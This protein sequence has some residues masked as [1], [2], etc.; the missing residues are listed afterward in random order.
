MDR[1]EAIKIINPETRCD[2]LRNY[3]YSERMYAVNE[4]CKIAV[5]YLSKDGGL[6][7]QKHGLWETHLLPLAWKCSVCG[8][9]NSFRSGKSTEYLNYCPCCG[10]KM[11]NIKSI[12]TIEPP[13]NDPLTLEELREMDGEPVWIVPTQE[14]VKPEYAL[15]SVENEWF[16][17]SNTDYWE[18]DVYG[19]AIIAYRRKPE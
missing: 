4:A 5:S 8:F 18:F 16:C 11:D 19:R 1:E 3:K 15:V 13:P 17:T 6:V 14:Y 9:K 2:A 12:P 10:A 7:V